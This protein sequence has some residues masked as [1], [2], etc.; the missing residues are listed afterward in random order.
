[1]AAENVAT[2]GFRADCGCRAITDCAHTAR[3][4]WHCGTKTWLR[5]PAPPLCA[6]RAM[7]LRWQQFLSPVLAT[8]TPRCFVNL[9]NE[10][11]VVLNCVIVITNSQPICGLASHAAM[12]TTSSGGSFSKY[13]CLFCNRFGCARAKLQFELLRARLCSK[14]MHAT[15]ARRP[16]LIH[17]TAQHSH[18]LE[19]VCLVCHAPK[20]KV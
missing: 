5:P 18:K 7:R 10:N 13:G 2:V 15:G 12:P 11:S 17:T 9:V 4:E 19:R 14:I 20:A 6:R 3:F 8:T 1:M 16:G